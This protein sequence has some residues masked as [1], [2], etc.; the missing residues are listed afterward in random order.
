MSESGM[1]SKLVKD[2]KS[3]DAIPV[4]NPVR[5]GTPD[6]NFIEGWIECKWL[7]R[8]PANANESPVLI[9]H[10]TPQQRIHLARRYLKGGKTFLM[11]E[12]G[13][14]WML[15]TGDVAANIVGRATRIQLEQNTF[16]H[17]KTGLKKQELITCLSNFRNPNVSSSKGVVMD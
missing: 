6:I 17:W 5:P 1:R 11:L 2:L 13:K 15:F 7:R 4:E 8:W 10:F 3:L 14:E 16:R 9:P 12:I